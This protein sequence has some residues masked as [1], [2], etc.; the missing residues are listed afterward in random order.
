[1]QH[2]PPYIHRGEDAIVPT[3]INDSPRA[4]IH[5][6]QSPVELDKTCNAIPNAC[7]RT[8][9]QPKKHCEYVQ[10]PKPSFIATHMQPTLPPS[11]VSCSDAQKQNVVQR[12]LPDNALQPTT[13]FL[14]SIYSVTASWMPAAGYS[15]QPKQ[16]TPASAFHNGLPTAHRLRGSKFV[17]T[18][19]QPNLHR[20]SS[21]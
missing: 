14:L 11:L 17:P 9:A 16:T 18:H 19:T 21:C 15:I 4:A 2:P 20:R 3:C 1:M 13:I 5:T 6:P 12:I 8:F 10:T 7:C